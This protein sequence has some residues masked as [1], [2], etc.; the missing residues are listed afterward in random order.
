MKHLTYRLQLDRNA[1]S[2][3]TKLLSFN[4]TVVVA[5]NAKTFAPSENDDDLI[6]SSVE[7]RTEAAVEAVRDAF[8]ALMELMPVILYYDCKISTYLIQ[9]A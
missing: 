3:L 6:F 5:G 8:T 7:E 1:L 4:P 9:L 2:D